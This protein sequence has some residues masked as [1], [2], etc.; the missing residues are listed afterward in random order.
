MQRDPLL[1]HAVRYGFTMQKDH[2]PG[3]RP[4]AEPRDFEQHVRT[5]VAQGGWREGL[6]HW[7]A[8]QLREH[9]A[10]LRPVD[11]LSSKTH[12]VERWVDRYALPLVL[13]KARPRALS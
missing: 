6:A 1:E 8:E 2:R 9:L 12:T 7:N 10:T 13:L 5:K 4:F 3:P 11:P